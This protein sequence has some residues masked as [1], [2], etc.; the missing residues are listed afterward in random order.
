[1]IKNTFVSSSTKTVR[2]A[3]L[4]CVLIGWS[5]ASPLDDTRFNLAAATDFISGMEIQWDRLGTIRVEIKPF[6]R[7]SILICRIAGTA[8]ILRNCGICSGSPF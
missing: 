7:I 1:L 6:A 8:V 2:D 5:S 3:C 4:D